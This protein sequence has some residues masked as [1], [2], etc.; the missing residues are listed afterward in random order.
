MKSGAFELFQAIS[1]PKKPNKH[2]RF[3]EFVTPFVTPS[4][5][6]LPAEIVLL[7]IREAL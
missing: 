5:V 6:L 7:P 1:N 2:S 4:K 3:A